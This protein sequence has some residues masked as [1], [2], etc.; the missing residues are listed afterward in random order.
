MSD[1]LKNDFVS[2]PVADA[3]EE[4]AENIVE[5]AAVE[6]VEEK[7]EETVT[8]EPE[9]VAEP[10]VEE[11]QVL[12]PVSNDGV[13]TTP[14]GSGSEN[15]NMVGLV[16]NG[17]IGSVSAPRPKRP[18]AKKSAPEKKAETVAI[19]S[20]RNVTWNGVGKVYRGYNIVEK[21]AADKWLTRDHIRLATPEEVAKEFGR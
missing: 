5:D 20:T 12:A 10:V 9:V 2:E 6:A 8:L 15:V 16:G 3:I 17:A 18:T 7:V 1:E 11:P 13:I 4:I 14:T 21:D 19:F